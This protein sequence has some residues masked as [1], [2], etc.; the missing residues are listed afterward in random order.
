MRVRTK[1]AEGLVDPGVAAARGDALRRPQRPAGRLRAR[2]RGS[3]HE[4]L[5]RGE[6]TGRKARERSRRSSAPSSALCLSPRSYSLIFGLVGN[7]KPMSTVT[8]WLN[9]NVWSSLL[10]WPSGKLLFGPEPRESKPAR[11]HEKG[12]PA[13]LDAER[14]EVARVERET[15]AEGRRDLRG[16]RQ[17]ER[18]GVVAGLPADAQSAR[19]LDADERDAARDVE[20]GVDEDLVE[21]GEL[22]AERDERDLRRHDVRDLR[23]LVGEGRGRGSPARRGTRSG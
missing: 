23:R 22:A 1:V 18:G 19:S 4:A 3:R 13:V 6:I 21:D 9:L 5:R 17:G 10:I 2:R 14:D 12:R 15:Q 20:V 11:F 8:N 7:E 16:R